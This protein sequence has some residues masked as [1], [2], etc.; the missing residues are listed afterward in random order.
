MQQADGRSKDRRE[1]ADR[2]RAFVSYAHVDAAHARWLQTRLENYRLPSRIAGAMSSV[3]REDRWTGRVGPVFRDREDLSASSDLSQAVREA[4]A[5]SRTLVVVCTP[6]TPG[7]Q[8]VAREIELFRELHPDGPRAT[9]RSSRSSRS[10]P[11]SSEVRS[12]N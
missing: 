8:W 2:F 11:G 10:W 5:D 3:D 12:T 1:R 9:G 6:A 7:S 4:L